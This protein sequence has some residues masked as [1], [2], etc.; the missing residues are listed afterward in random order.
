[1]TTGVLYLDEGT[2]NYD[3]H[4]N[5]ASGVYQWLRIWATSIKNHI[6]R[7]NYSDTPEALDNGVSNAV[8]DE[9][10]KIP[11][12]NVQAF[13]AVAVWMVLSALYLLTLAGNHTESEDALM[14][15]S[16]IRSGDV[17]GIFDPYHLIYGWYA[18][19]AYHAA[20][21]LGYSGGPLLPAQVLD[22]FTGA[23]GIALLWHLLRTAIP[24]R[25]A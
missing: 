6:V 17:S 1:M 3:V 12:R 13:E 7:Y 19:T 14:Y 9:H 20:L 15:L 18:W 24:N 23:L 11:L 22:A 21:A 10:Q 5:V 16:R 8:I 4:H 25:V 2:Q